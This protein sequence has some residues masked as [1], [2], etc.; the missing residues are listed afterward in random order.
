MTTMFFRCCFVAFVF[1]AAR[2]SGP[3]FGR[4]T[5]E[6]REAEVAMLAE[7][8]FLAATNLIQVG[9][10]EEGGGGGGGGLGE[11]KVGKRRHVDYLQHRTQT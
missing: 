4:E 2:R 10:S 8:N 7:R 9:A 1:G 11:L 6:A 3:L 5:P